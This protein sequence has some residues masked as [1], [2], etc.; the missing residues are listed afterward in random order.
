MRRAKKYQIIIASSYSSDSA[1]CI[2]SKISGCSKQYEKIVDMTKRSRERKVHKARVEWDSL[3]QDANQQWNIVTLVVRQKERKTPREQN[4]IKYALS[5][6]GH[7]LWPS[8][9][10]DCAYMFVMCLFLLFP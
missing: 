6:N 5:V 2:Y 1:Q 3:T 9:C 7:F 10:A 8:L 4:T